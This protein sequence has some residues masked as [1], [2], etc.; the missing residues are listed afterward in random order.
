M[1]VLALEAST[2]A[3]KAA[4]VDEKGRVLAQRQM[5][6]P[7]G[8]GDVVTLD[9]DAVLDVLLE[10][11]RQAVK[12]AGGIDAAGL[13]TI[14]QSLLPLDARGRPLS[15]AWTWAHTGAGET[16]SAIRLDANA[17]RTYYRRTGCIP[18]SQLPVFQAR[19][20]LA[21]EPELKSVAQWGS[22]ASYLL[23]KLT[24]EGRQSTCAAAGSG[25]LNLES[26]EYDGMA[27]ELSGVRMEQLPPLCEPDEGFPLLPDI[28]RRLGVGPIPLAAGGGD[29]G[30]NQIGSGGLRP[31]VMTVSIGTSAALRI[32][33]RTPVLPEPP[34]TWCY[35]G[36][37]GWYVAGAATSGACNCVDWVRH[38]LL[39]DA[40]FA[41]LEQAME[42]RRAKWG[43]APVFLPFLWGERCPGWREDRAGGYLGLRGEHQ[44]GDLYYAALEGVLLLLRRCYDIVTASTGEPEILSVSGGILNSRP[45]MQMA[46]D[47]FGRPVEQSRNA[48]ASLMGAAALALCAGG[49]LESA[50]D[51]PVERGEFIQPDPA[52]RQ[53]YAARLTRFEEAMDHGI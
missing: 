9:P 46:A 47:V 35:Y 15:R 45:W 23:E 33:S 44:V 49:A 6:Y 29:G 14:W 41:Q 25:W 21:N 2:Q 16:A 18:H 50:S 48:N 17:C 1:R 24:G 3:A 37:Q 39:A 26:M 28:Q 34:A 4:V 36:A 8:V 43:E 13:C 52:M 11:G 10:T 53:H 51:F 22:M 12:E 30:L 5:A 38:T 42:E 20:R 40:P 19:H 31:G 32:A 7:D 27:L